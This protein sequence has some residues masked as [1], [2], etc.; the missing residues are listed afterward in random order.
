[1]CR[2]SLQSRLGRRRRSVQSFERLSPP[3]Q[4]DRPQSRLG[5]TG[6]DACHRIVEGE[7]RIERGPKLDRP[8]Q[9]DQIPVA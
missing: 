7:Q 4:L 1:M 9:P 6:Y 8:V 5:R 3:G 2:D